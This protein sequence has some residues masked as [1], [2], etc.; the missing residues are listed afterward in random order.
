MQK[1]DNYN[2]L[3][4][5][6]KL[7]PLALIL[8]FAVTYFIFIYVI[9][10]TKAN[11]VGMMFLVYLPVTLG[12]LVAYFIQ[13]ETHS[14]KNTHLLLF[15]TLF[16]S[17]LICSLLLGEGVICIVIASPILYIMMWIG[18]ECTH[19]ICKKFWQSNTLLSVVFIPF[20]VMFF[21][22]NESIYD[23]HKEYSII[24]NASPQQVWHGINNISDIKPDEFSNSWSAK[25][26][27]PMPLSATT[28]PTNDTPSGL[29]RKCLWHKD[30]WFD[31]PVTEY[32][33]NKKL[34][35]YFKFYPT[36]VPKGSLDDHVTINGDHYKLLEASYELEELSDKQTKLTFNVHYQVITDINWYSGWWADFFMDDFAENVLQLYKNRLE[37]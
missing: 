3:N 8:L 21:P 2:N 1:T 22:H 6:T 4:K 36:S 14:R 35:W 33:P 11:L 25:I 20:I 26:G 19:Y 32:T 13:L 29:V 15:L 24:I 12:A 7:I 16:I 28:V 10:A 18:A 37:S 23:S 5:K 30:I 27:V 17:F 31:E 34:A 9:G